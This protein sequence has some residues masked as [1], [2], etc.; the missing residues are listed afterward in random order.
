MEQQEMK[1]SVLILLTGKLLTGDCKK[2]IHL[3]TPQEGGKWQVD[4]RPFCAHT[5]SVEDIQWSPNED[6]VRLQQLCIMIPVFINLS[7]TE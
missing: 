2:N 5:S 6:N 7:F 4:Q 3:W 1:C